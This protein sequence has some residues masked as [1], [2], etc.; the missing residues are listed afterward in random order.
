MMDILRNQVIENKVIELILSQA[1]FEE[2]PYEP[3][4]EDAYGLD[5]AL[6]GVAEK[7]SEGAESPSAGG[8]TGA[9][10]SAGQ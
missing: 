3:Q 2:K 1:Q 10:A 6:T 4:R 5:L 8:G 7:E 9:E